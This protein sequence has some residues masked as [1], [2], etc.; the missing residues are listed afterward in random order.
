MPALFDPFLQRTFQEDKTILTKT[1]VPIATISASY[2]EDTKRLHG[3]PHNEVETDVVFS[4]A[5][6]S[7][8]LGFLITAGGGS[9]DATKAWMVDPTNYV[10]SADWKNISFTEVVGKTIARHSLLKKVKDGIDRF[11][12]QKLP[13]LGSITPPLLYLTGHIQRPIVSFHIAAGNI[14]AGQ[15]KTVVQ[16]VT[17][18]HVREEYVEYAHLPHCHYCV[19]DAKTKL[20]FLEI[21]RYQNK[22]VNPAR[23]HITGPPIDPRIIAARKHKKPWRNGVLKLCITTG[24]LG[25]N[26]QEILEVLEQLL[27]E[28]RRRQSPY[29]L[30]VYAGTHQD[31]YDSV[32]E[33]AK[34]EHVAVGNQTDK[35]AK[36]RVLYHPQ[37]VDANE[38]LIQYGFPWADGFITKPSGDMAYD[39]VAA[40]CFLYTLSEWGEWEH[41]VWEVF[42]QKNIARKL[43][44]EHVVAQ[45]EVLTSAHGKAQS[46]VE[47]AIRSAQTIEPLF[48]HGCEEILEV[49]KRL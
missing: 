16:V 37:L 36:L 7:M 13:I 12:R 24:G 2:K 26:K 19:F 33:L 18:P 39:A 35:A 29:Q 34:K 42:S 17:D 44:L 20:E 38:L 31:I 49:C 11:G 41:S 46:W 6:Y 25:T 27:P 10:S 48:L 3:Y 32:L 45:L 30:L 22:Q 43:E 21:A 47:Q 4:R 23:V 8:A 5:H 28:L 15:G 40:G 1:K 14:L 9:I